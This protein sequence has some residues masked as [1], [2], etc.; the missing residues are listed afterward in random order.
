M[1]KP[2]AFGRLLQMKPFLALEQPFDAHAPGEVAGPFEAND[3]SVGRHNR[4][5]TARLPVGP[6]EF[7]RT[8]GVTHDPDKT[9]PV[10]M[11]VSSA[12]DQSLPPQARGHYN[13]D[14]ENEGTGRS[15]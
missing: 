13:N 15:V 4:V 1:R 12:M 6:E 3:P 11:T 2:G 5:G 10:A 14:R 7:F 8:G 9:L